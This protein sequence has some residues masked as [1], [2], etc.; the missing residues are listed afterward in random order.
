MNFEIILDLPIHDL[1]K[2]LNNLIEANTIKWHPARD[3]ICINTTKDELDNY[4]YGRGSLWYDWDKSYRNENNELIVPTRKKPLFEKDFA[5]L[6]TVF[7]GTLF[8]DVYRSLE[9]KYVL[10][11]VRI[12]NLHSKNCLTWHKDNSIRVHYPIKTQEGCFM[13]IDNEIKHLEQNIW[14]RTDT[15]KNHTVFN[16]SKED[17]LHLVATILEE[18]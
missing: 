10:G 15:L 7:A 6:C 12:M 3:Q 8:E 13:I 9:R 4:N 16:G 2:E 5:H 18:K 14:Y 17:R 1:N 11:R